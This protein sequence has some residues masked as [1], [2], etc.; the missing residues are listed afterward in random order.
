MGPKEWHKGN[1]CSAR[2]FKE[3]SPNLRRVKCQIVKYKKMLKKEE[4]REVFVLTGINL[5]KFW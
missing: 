3:E 2:D 4:M 1:N 5:F